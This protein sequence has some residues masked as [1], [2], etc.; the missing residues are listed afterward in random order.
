MIA[1]RT[2][3]V[4]PLLIATLLAGGGVSL[5][6]VAVVAPAAPGATAA[7][8]TT[9]S[10]TPRPVKDLSRKKPRTVKKLIRTV[11]G[12]GV[13]ATHPDP[14]NSVNVDGN[15]W[16]RDYSTPCVELDCVR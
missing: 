1:I 2:R 11:E 13:G 4:V 10:D 14:F 16:A 5:S 3:R 7:G 9:D 6:S 12:S 8:L 15:E